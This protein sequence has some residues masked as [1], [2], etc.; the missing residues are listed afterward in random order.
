[1]GAHTSLLM[2]MVLTGTQSGV[3]TRTCMHGCTHISTRAHGT[4]RHAVWGEHTYMYTHAHARTLTHMCAC[5]TCMHGAR[6][7]IGGAVSSIYAYLSATWGSSLIHHLLTSP[8]P[9]LTYLLTY[10]GECRV[11]QPHPSVAR[12]AAVLLQLGRADRRGE[13]VSGQWSVVSGQ[14]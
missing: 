8:H 11:G 1:M 4:D 12:P 6:T 9:L 13:Q 5:R 14:W 3:S 7:Y 10:L 2:L